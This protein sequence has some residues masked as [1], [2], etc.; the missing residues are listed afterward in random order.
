M[1]GRGQTLTI[2]ISTWDKR[3]EGAHTPVSF[4]VE[5]LICA[6]RCTSQQRGTHFVAGNVEVGVA[7]GRAA[8]RS[9]VGSSCLVLGWEGAS[10]DE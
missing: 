6:V 8:G 9:G 5:W 10:T 4:A 3:L 1:N 2:M 7:A